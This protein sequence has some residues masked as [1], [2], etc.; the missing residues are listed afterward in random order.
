VEG[1]TEGGVGISVDNRQLTVDKSCQLFLSTVNYS[2]RKVKSK[3]QHPPQLPLRFFR[4]YCNPRLQDYIEGDLMEVYE[5]RLKK[6]G[7][8]IADVRFIID[9]LLLFRPGIMKS[10]HERPYFNN[11]SMY[12]N[13]LLIGWR[14]LVRSK[15]HSFF[16]ISGL[17]LGIASCLLIS[18]YIADELSY[19]TYHKHAEKIQ[20]VVASDWAKMPP[21]L[22]PQ[23]K[24]A[25]PHLVEQSVRFW[26]LFSPAKIRHNEKVFVE[27]GVVFTDPGVFSIF[28]WP[29]VAGNPAK[30]LMDKNSIVLTK[31]MANK[32]FGDEDPMGK[33][34]KFWGNDLTVTGVMLEVPANSH[35]SFDFLISFSTLHMVMGNE[36]DNNWGMPTFYTYL[37]PADGVSSSDL[38]TAAQQLFK[39]N[40]PDPS[41]AISLQPLTSI[42]LESNLQA[43]FKPG[44]NKS[45]LYIL[46]SAAL[47]ILVLA[48]INFTNLNIARASTRVKEV[49]MRKS[50]GALRLQLIHQFFGEALVTTVI[51]LLLGLVV[52]GITTPA[53]NQFFGK[54]ITFDSLLTVPFF[55]GIVVVMLLVSFCAGAYPAL[56]LASLKPVTS[57]KG[58][59]VRTG[60]FSVRK[61]LIV[62]QFAVSTFFLAAMLVVLQ[63]LNFL[64]N[65]DMGFDKDQ[66][67]VLDGDGFPQLRTEFKKIAGVEEVTGVPQ[68]IPGLL[69]RSAYRTQDVTT[70]S[71]SQMSYFGVA[72]P[73]VETMG[74]KLLAGRNFVESS[75]KDEQEAFI[76]NESAVRELGWE[77][78][79]DAVGKPFSMFVP[80]L[81]GGAEV[82][83]HGTIIG[84]VQDFHFKSLYSRIEPLVLYPSYD[85]N[86]TLVRAQ[87][88]AT[89]ILAM[90]KV[91]KQ[92]N[93]DAPFTCFYLNDRIQEQYTTEFKLGSLIATATGLTMIIACMGLLGLVAL[94]ANQ[95]TKE[96]GIRKVMGASSVQVITLLTKDFILLVG[97]SAVVALPLSFYALNNWISHFAY[98]ID[99]SI[100][101]FV[102]TTLVTIIIATLTV[103]AQ[104]LKIS[105]SPVTESLRSE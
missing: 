61:S 102:L 24:E 95:R 85:L 53:F 15:T 31:S 56:F 100:S 72:G 37:L 89:T 18:L 60:N 70:D 75:K 63:Q 20:R 84:V 5:K 66:V 71:T 68:L 1:Y 2:I 82:W 55:G 38:Q 16:N 69:P 40:F 93:P 73:F 103:V 97:I 74:I 59:G 62:F 92:I 27:S 81:E 19:D 11:W 7:K 79:S 87:N 96:I 36:L 58:I 48:A 34:L 26:P 12:K 78:I 47:F 51:A 104:S 22:A 54:A 10:T 65:K 39:T 64:Q 28:T 14:N 88:N 21:A 29:L 83:R 13:Y 4:W 6:S 23:I 42:H 105:T 52:V 86:L 8:G 25:Y 30:A 43:E 101:T 3:K 77:N 33:Q 91:W 99:L 50:L 9:V 94:S 41:V 17:A 57:L 80:P 98:H 46:G 35:L 67:F 76:L 45:Y 49:G 32:Y 90:E 44:G